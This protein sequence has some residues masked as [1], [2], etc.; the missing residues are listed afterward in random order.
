[1]E[2]GADSELGHGHALDRGRL[3]YK[4]VL[5]KLSGEA[6][7]GTQ[8]FGIAPEVVSGLANELAR[9]L[10]AGCQ[11]GLV[12]GG[13]NIFRGV[14]GSRLGMDRVRA[15]HIGM[16]ATVMNSLALQDALM[17][18]GIDAR[19]LSAL[20]IEGVCEPCIRKRAL[21]HLERGR[22]VIF[23]AGTGN[24][25]FTTDT[26]AALRAL[27]IGAECLFKATKVNGVYDK[28]PAVHK[29][30]QR[31]SRLT[32]HEVIERDLRVMDHA[33]ISLA[34]DAGLPVFVFDMRETGNILKALEGHESIGTL[35]T[36][37]WKRWRKEHY[38]TS[39]SRRSV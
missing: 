32:Y 31:F 29:D 15:D 12:I 26:A 35:V 10:R 21:K 39:C 24:P 2:G 19:V 20:E 4:R 23:A 6:L 37:E 5:L 13:G 14:A 34:M 11:L 30:A 36:D 27:E 9:A 25:F 38:E 1:M 7:M 18:Q 16:L 8:S 17:Q 28:D 33:A 3:K 22:I